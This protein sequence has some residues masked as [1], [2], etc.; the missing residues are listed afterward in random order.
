MRFRC[1]RNSYKKNQE[2]GKTHNVFVFQISVDQILGMEIGHCVKNHV[3]DGLGLRLVVRISRVKVAAAAKFQHQVEPIL[4]VVRF[5]GA[6][7]IGMV[8]GAQN[9]N[10]IEKF[11][12]ERGIGDATEDD[13]L[14]CI[15]D[16]L[17]SGVRDDGR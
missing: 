3:H 16:I 8:N 14:E 10:L 5:N 11:F 1:K 15:H 12:S 2:S 6:N 13:G 7:N 9:S 17:F 4:I